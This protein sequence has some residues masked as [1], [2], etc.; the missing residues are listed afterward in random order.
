MHEGKLADAEPMFREALAGCR[1]TL[2]DK[3]PETLVSIGNVAQRK[4][5]A[6]TA[7]RPPPPPRPPRAGLQRDTAPMS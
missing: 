1:E 3:H 6:T 4:G 5:A 2:G 7:P